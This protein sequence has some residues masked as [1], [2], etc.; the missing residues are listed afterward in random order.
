[1][2]QIFAANYPQVEESEQLRLEASHAKHLERKQKLQMEFEEKSKAIPNR[3]YFDENIEHAQNSIEV[4]TE[5]SQLAAASEGKQIEKRSL[6][7]DIEEQADE[8]N[9]VSNVLPENLTWLLTAV[10]FSINFGQTTKTCLARFSNFSKRFQRILPIHLAIACKRIWS[11][12]NASRLD[13]KRGMRFS[14]RIRN[15]SC[16]G[17]IIERK[18]KRLLRY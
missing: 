6:E 1:L 16:V 13:H 8:Y 17:K 11:C 5:N 14:Q 9:W 18:I 10:S 2:Y 4:E 7:N 3:E 15:T 12:R